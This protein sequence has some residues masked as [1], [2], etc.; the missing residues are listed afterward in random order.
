MPSDIRIQVRWSVCAR[1][2]QPVS[3]LYSILSFLSN[4]GH[5]KPCNPISASNLTLGT[6]VIGAHTWKSDPTLNSWCVCRKT[7]TYTRRIISPVTSGR[8]FHFHITA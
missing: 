2:I 7:R 4:A 5:L 6:T 1:W 8:I 3:T